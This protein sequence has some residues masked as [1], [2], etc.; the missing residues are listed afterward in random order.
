MEGTV[1]PN[2]TAYSPFG[3]FTLFF[4]I[5]FK[6]PRIM[7]SL[8]TFYSTNF[9]LVLII[10]H[11]CRLPR[12]GHLECLAPNPGTAVIPT[13]PPTP[14]PHPAPVLA[15]TLILLLILLLLQVLLLLHLLLIFLL[16]LHVCNPLRCKR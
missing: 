2:L 3:K 4:T 5:K 9:T 16:V 10:L 14:A 13:S 7:Y 12:L 6:L 15:L 8:L 1:L 11:N